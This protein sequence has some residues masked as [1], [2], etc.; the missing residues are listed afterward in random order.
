M[1][2]LSDW[3]APILEDSLAENCKASW[4]QAFGEIARR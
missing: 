3:K 1:T 2:A 4:I